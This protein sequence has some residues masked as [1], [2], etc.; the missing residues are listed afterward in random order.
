MKIFNKIKENFMVKMLNDY[1]ESFDFSVPI[2]L[3]TLIQPI[4]KKNP[5]EGENIIHA[6]QGANWVYACVREISENIGTLPIKVRH[7]KTLGTVDDSKVKDLLYYVNEISNKTDFIVSLVA[8]LELRGEFFILKDGMTV[9]N[10]IPKRLYVKDPAQFKYVLASDGT[11]INH[12]VYR[13][14]TPDGKEREMNIKPENLVYARYFNPMHPIRGMAPLEAAR[15]SVLEE[16]QAKQYNINFFQNDASVGGVLETEGNIQDSV[17]RRLEE[18]IRQKYSGA[19]NA[20]KTMILEGGLKYKPISLNHKDMQYLETRKMSREEI[21]AVFRVPPPVVGIFEYASYANSEQSYISFWTKTLL[22]KIK[23]IQDIFNKF[24]FDVY[25]PDYFMEFDITEVPVLQALLSKKMDIAIKM[26]NIG[27]PIDIIDEKLNIDFLKDYDLSKVDLEPGDNILQVFS[28]DKNIPSSVDLDSVISDLVNKFETKYDKKI[29]QVWDK[30][31]NLPQGNIH[32]KYI[33]DY[34]LEIGDIVDEFYITFD[35]C[36][37]KLVNQAESLVSSY[38]DNIKYI[39]SKDYGKYL[40]FEDVIDFFENL[41]KD[42]NYFIF[43]DSYVDNEI[44]VDYSRLNDILKTKQ[45]EFL[46]LIKNNLYYLFNAFVYESMKRNNVHE[47]IWYST[48][49]N[50]CREIHAHNHN[51]CVVLGNRFSNGEIF[52]LSTK[53]NF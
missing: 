36:K 33:S 49:I 24:F 10:K 51:E 11:R 14:L 32:Q 16:Y 44:K 28:S 37:D 23:L 13:Y 45:D 15:N 29:Q 34:T 2:T 7:K 17:F 25:E 30:I 52:P 53:N 38:I 12:W 1:F 39:S 48:D 27:Y 40:I 26:R 4:N 21:C 47:V 20:G 42:L 41:E 8:Y 3:Q 22:P 9:R 46:L 35:S 43:V 50:S 18:Q 5:Y 31:K 6:Y 19:E